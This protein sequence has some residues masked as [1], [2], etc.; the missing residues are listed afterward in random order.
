MYQFWVIHGLDELRLGWCALW[1]ILLTTKLHISQDDPARNSM[2]Y[3]LGIMIHSKQPGIWYRSRMIFKMIKLY[4]S[5]LWDTNINKP[6]HACHLCKL[7]ANSNLRSLWEGLRNNKKW[8]LVRECDCGESNTVISENLVHMWFDV[9]KNQIN[10]INPNKSRKSRKSHEI[11]VRRC[12]WVEL[13]VYDTGEMY[14][15]EH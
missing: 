13:I 14:V 2:Y 7:Q 8:K 6:A 1:G 10:Q 3:L 11:A 5:T 12:K 9:T 15:W 4:L